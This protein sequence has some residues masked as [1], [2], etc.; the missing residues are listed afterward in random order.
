MERYQAQHRRLQRNHF[1]QLHLLH[2]VSDLK[3]KAEAFISANIEHPQTSL[4]ESSNLIIWFSEI[5]A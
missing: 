1:N 5:P 4:I 2:F 3:I